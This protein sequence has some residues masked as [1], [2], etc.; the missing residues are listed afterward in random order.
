[1]LTLAERALGLTGTELRR[2]FPLFAYLF[3]TMAS[4]VASKAA[5]D[6]LFLDRYRAI[7]LPYVDIAIA[8]LVG[9][10]ASIY[11]RVGHRTNLRN[12]QV[13]SLLFFALNALFFWL[14]AVIASYESGAL[15]IVIYIWVGVFS[16]LAPSQVWTRARAITIRTRSLGPEIGGTVAP[17]C[18]S[19]DAQIS[20]WRRSFLAIRSK[21]RARSGFFSIVARL[22]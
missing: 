19:R 11:I 15:F 21:T 7:D 6:A 20:A 1:L 12:L 18:S 17:A 8:V 5:R 3:L 14:W 2:A 10:A 13:G 4:S 22:S 9:L 16:V